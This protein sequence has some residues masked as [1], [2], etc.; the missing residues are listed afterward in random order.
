[1]ADSEE[2]EFFQATQMPEKKSQVSATEGGKMSVVEYFFLVT[3]NWDLMVGS[4][5]EM[6]VCEKIKEFPEEWIKNRLTDYKRQIRIR[7]SAL[8]GGEF[9]LFCKVEKGTF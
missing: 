4:P 1:M 8:G 2:E 7:V 6:Y 3:F 5:F 9:S